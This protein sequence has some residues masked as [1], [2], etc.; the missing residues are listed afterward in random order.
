M[1]MAD[2]YGERAETQQMQQPADP[3]TPYEG[4]GGYAPPPGY[5]A[6][7]GY[8]PRFWSFRTYPRPARLPRPLD[9]G[10]TKPFTLTSELGI[11]LVAVFALMITAAASSS[12][13]PRFFWIWTSVMVSAYMISRGLAKAGSSSRAHDAGE[14]PSDSLGRRQG[15]ERRGAPER[16]GGVRIG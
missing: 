12:I 7:Y 3:E 5:G 11:G 2:P 8:G 14:E 10:E 15:G 9:P 16:S 13:G 4:P 1:S 6:G